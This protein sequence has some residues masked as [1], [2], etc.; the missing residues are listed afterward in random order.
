VDQD[1]AVYS[2]PFQRRDPDITRGEF[3][4]DYHNR[5]DQYRAKAI[6][7]HNEEENLRQGIRR[8]VD[9]DDEGREEACHK[10][11][12]S[13][14]QRWNDLA[15]E[16]VARET[17]RRIQLE[18]KVYRENAPGLAPLLADRAEDPC[19]GSRDGGP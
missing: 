5:E 17:N 6:A 19:E 4:P 14:Y 7:F 3:S 18:N 8:M 16:F 2:G 11:Y 13:I 10:G 1:Q 12:G 9:L 15:S